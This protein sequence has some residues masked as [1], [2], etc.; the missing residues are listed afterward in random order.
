MECNIEWEVHSTGQAK[1]DQNPPLT[2][3][4]RMGQRVVTSLLD[5][6]SSISMIRAHLVPDNR[7]TLSLTTVAGVHCQVYK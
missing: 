6:G 2:I 3:P 4:V 5:T 1:A 7:P